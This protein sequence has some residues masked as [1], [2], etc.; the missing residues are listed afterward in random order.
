MP[1]PPFLSAADIRQLAPMSDVIET[2]RTVFQNRHVDPPRAIVDLSVDETHSRTLL[3]MPTTL[4]GVGGCKL[5]SVF[6]GNAAAGL[7]AIQGIYVL[8]SEVDGRIRALLDGAVL[9]E[10][11]TP[12]ASALATDYLAA[13]G[14][15]SLAVFGTG[16]QAAAHV[17]AMLVVRQGIARVVCVS[18][19]A[20]RADEFASRMSSRHGI[21]AVSGRT[22][23]AMAC[24]IVCTTTRAS[25]PLFDAS[26]LLGST[27]I[28]AVGSFKP[29]QSE[30]TASVVMAAEV[31]VDH[32]DAA[33]E[34]AGELIQAA[35][36]GTW[37][38]DDLAGDI[39]DLV[40]NPGVPRSAE[41]TLFKS[42]GLPVEDIA[43]ARLVADR[44]GLRP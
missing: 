31:Y 24:D 25:E 26:D 36:A 7:P 19:T 2:L 21:E 34:E 5:I 39:V 1:A 20:G 33:A 13:E 35:Q 27:H 10:L 11:R 37:S 41:T 29:N 8:F 6:P 42:V 40:L 14:A 4:D 9:T 28:N 3:S 30:F 44:A 38:W 43:V 16:V 23:E 17:E 15:E 22:K 18:G 12:A 32:R